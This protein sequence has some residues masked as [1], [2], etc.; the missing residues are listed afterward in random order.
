MHRSYMRR[1]VYPA[2]VASRPY[3]VVY[4]WACGQLMSATPM[5]DDEFAAGQREAVASAYADDPAIEV[6]IVHAASPGDVPA[7]WRGDVRS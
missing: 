5:V 4:D 1:A 7:A 3:L 6:A 2:V